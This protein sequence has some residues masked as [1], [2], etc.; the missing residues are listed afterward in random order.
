MDMRVGPGEGGGFLLEQMLVA[1]A[2]AV[3]KPNRPPAVLVNERG[4]HAE[5]WRDADSAADQHHRLRIGGLEGKITQGGAQ[6]EDVSL[7][8]LVVK[9]AGAEP[10]GRGAGGGG[11]RGPGRGRVIPPL[12]VVPGAGA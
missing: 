11:A 5:D 10:G 3:E 4:Q 1:I 9:N 8:D 6:V 2:Q 12:W 7:P